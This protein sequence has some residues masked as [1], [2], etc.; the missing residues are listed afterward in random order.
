MT[1]GRISDVAALESRSKSA[2]DLAMRGKMFQV[3][4]GS[5]EHG[6]TLLLLTEIQAATRNQ[7]PESQFE[8][9]D[10]QSLREPVC[11]SLV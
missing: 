7:N 11:S 5:C 2:F 1:R 6:N 9:Y 10:A 4:Q 8:R 3:L